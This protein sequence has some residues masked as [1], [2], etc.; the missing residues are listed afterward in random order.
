MGEVSRSFLYALSS[1]ELDS[2]RKA[3]MAGDADA[4][5]S[6]E[7]NRPLN[8]VPLQQDDAE[9]TRWV[10]IVQS[11]DSKRVCKT[12]P[13]HLDRVA[14]LS[15]IPRS[16]LLVPEAGDRMFDLPRGTWFVMPLFAL[17]C[18]VRLPLNSVY[19]AYLAKHGLSPAQLT[20]GA[21]LRMQ[22]LLVHCWEQR[23][24]PSVH[25]FDAV[26]RIG[27]DRSKVAGLYS[28]FPRVKDIHL[29]DG[30]KSLKGWGERYCWVNNGRVV[31]FGQWQTQAPAEVVIRRLH[32]QAAAPLKG[33]ETKGPDYESFCDRSFDDVFNLVG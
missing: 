5:L 16:S 3:R 28:L 9:S 15:G 12:T 23:L 1:P 24:E 30:P 11:H 20:G 17:H 13:G 7:G 21:W 2:S 29:F 27:P 33:V 32:E 4:W 19:C 18:G 14:E 22:A 8:V 6:D 25:L 31:A 26:F 10:R